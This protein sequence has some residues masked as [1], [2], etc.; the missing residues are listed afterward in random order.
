MPCH[1]S[2]RKLLHHLNRYISGLS[3]VRDKW[4]Y[5]TIIEHLRDSKSRI[6][7]AF[8]K[9]VLETLRSV[10][11]TL[12]LSQPLQEK[13][14]SAS[15]KYFVCIYAVLWKCTERRT[16]NTEIIAQWWLSQLN[17][18]AVG[19]GTK[20]WKYT[21]LVYIYHWVYRTSNL[22]NFFH[23]VGTWIKCSLGCDLY[24]LFIYILH[25]IFSN[26]LDQVSH[27]WRDSVLYLFQKFEGD[28]WYP[29]LC[30]AFVKSHGSCSL[31]CFL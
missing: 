18:T 24:F 3:N 27:F 12:V 9:N 22:H 11:H 31:K 28:S 29:N 5:Y 23:R 16:W 15:E 8:L 30:V 6:N 17:L 13:S 21:V 25:L 7:E 10:L 26:N 4:V 14:F 1:S 2:F 20:S 19:K